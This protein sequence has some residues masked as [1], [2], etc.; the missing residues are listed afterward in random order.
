M[1][2]GCFSAVGASVGV[3]LAVCLLA[4]YG[5]PEAKA[6]CVYLDGN[7]CQ[8]ALWCSQIGECSGCATPSNGVIW[9]IYSWVNAAG[10]D[11]A[12]VDGAACSWCQDVLCG[13]GNSFKDANC[14]VRLSTSNCYIFNAC[15]HPK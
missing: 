10:N 2:N 8:N 5:L 7:Q 11:C 15:P 12:V 6:Y 3:F 13:T 4:D 14:T 9:V 1:R